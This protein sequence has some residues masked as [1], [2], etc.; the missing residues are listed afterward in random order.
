MVG[1]LV[2]A[3]LLAAWPIQAATE[4]TPTTLKAAV[5]YD[6]LPGS[7]Q[8]FAREVAA[9]VRAAG[10]APD[11]VFTSV[12]TNQALL[13]PKRYDLLALP[14]AR[15]LPIAAASA[16]VSY[17]RGGGDLLAL[18]LP[19]WQSP[20]F[21][22]N[23][24]W[25]TLQSYEESIA[26]QRPLHIVEDFERADLSRWARH[27]GEAGT[28]AQY[29]LSEQAND[30]H[31]KAL[32][33]RL[34]RL[35]GWQTLESPAL[36][37]PFPTNHTLTCFR[38]KGGPRTRQLSLEWRERDGSRW[39]A[40]VD[41]TP[42]WQDYSLL[43]A[44]F[45]AWPLDSV[46]KD[47]SFDPSQAA[48][49][50]VGL[51]LSHT[52]LEGDQHEYWFDD[53]GTAPNPLGDDTLPALSGVPQL[54]SISPSYQCFPITT[55][56]VVRADHLKSPLEDWERS[57]PKGD[58]RDALSCVGLH[59]RARGVGF[60]QGRPY[61][62]EPL[63]GAYDA[64]TQDYRG[65]MAALVVNVAPPLRGSVWAVFT[66]ADA[67]FYRQAV[68]TNCLH[69]V[70]ARMRRGVFLSEG[71]SEFF[72]LFAGQQFQAG[73]RVVNFGRE[74]AANLSLAVTL[75]D[76]K[77]RAPRAVLQTNF[78]VAPGE[79]VTLARG[80][81]A[82]GPNEDTVSLTLTQAAV[83]IDAL[84]HELGVWQPKARP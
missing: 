76:A 69:Q 35:G 11:F 50:C 40:T 61:R 4:Q 82:K 70:L 3:I 17:L 52:A 16:I 78:T 21:Q 62:W 72:T 49:W 63:L 64:A 73:A 75:L 32:H 84:R 66:P 2:L 44:R 30:G 71:G 24:K 58:K 20:V 22:I 83:P 81:L 41:L 18:G 34:D 79:S 14:N 15:A 29:E 38:A 33:V 51:A 27:T 5:F 55:P 36:S 12:L 9:Q 43:P 60:E 46:S 39:I 68:V 47:R 13:T 80:D 31:G 7:D 25:L 59:P 6:S 67:D 45:K 26:A 10:Y 8:A 54:E 1:L 56:V 65:A 37:Q 48:I 42:E 28:M 23:G 19:A 77:G 74:T 57:S 53:L